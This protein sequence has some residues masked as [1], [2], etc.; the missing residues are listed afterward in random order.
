[1]SFEAKPAAAKSSQKR[2]PFI[3]RLLQRGSVSSKV[4]V[5]QCTQQSVIRHLAPSSSVWQRLAD[6]AKL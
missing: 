6:G 3:V 4:G 5:F 1:M 2:A